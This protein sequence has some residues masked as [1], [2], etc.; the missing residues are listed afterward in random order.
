MEAYEMITY[1]LMD[2]L[3]IFNRL[4]LHAGPISS[5]LQ[6]IYLFI[7]VEIL[8]FSGIVVQMLKRKAWS[9]FPVGNADQETFLLDLI[10]KDTRLFRFRQRLGELVRHENLQ[11]SSEIY[12][13][14]TRLG[15]DMGVVQAR[16]ESVHNAVSLIHS[17]VGDV[18][19][20][21]NRIESFSSGVRKLRSFFA[22]IPEMA[23][24][25][26]A[27]HD[28]FPQIP[29][30][31]IGKL[32]NWL[33][34]HD[35]V[36]NDYST[37]RVSRFAGTCEWFLENPLYKAWHSKPSS[38]LFW[39]HG[40]PG[41]GKSVLSSYLVETEIANCIYFFF[42]FDDANK[43][44][45]QALLRSA[46]FQL[47][48]QYESIHD[49]LCKLC[50]QGLDLDRLQLGSLWQKIFAET[51]LKV[52]VTFYW[53]IDGLDECATDRG[54]LVRLLGEALKTQ[55]TIKIILVSRFSND[56][57]K[58]IR[59]LGAPVY[60]ITPADNTRDIARYVNTRMEGLLSVEHRDTQDELVSEI[61]GRAH[62]GF[63]WTRL[64]LDRLEAEHSIEGMRTALHEMPDKLVTVYERIVE[65][66]VSILNPSQ[67]SLA[68]A[69]FMYVIVA[70]RPLSLN[71]IAYVLQSQFGSLRSIKATIRDI[72]GSMI[73][74]GL[75]DTIH[76]IHM[77][78][79]QYLV[80]CG[81]E[82]Q[83]NIPIADVS[84]ATRCLEYLLTDLPDPFQTHSG[85]LQGQRQA[86]QNRHSFLDYAAIHWATHLSRASAD[87]QLLSLISQFIANPN[88]LKWLQYLA[89]AGKF[90]V[91][92]VVADNLEYYLD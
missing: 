20:T 25:M 36:V 23:L 24:S 69:I 48:E 70:V 46:A 50:D 29:E 11:L 71:E 44:Q 41:S 19:S 9:M 83:I 26:C 22:K 32:R 81:G 76:T 68:K 59:L 18:S 3:L 72:C 31:G 90:D 77:T 88:I 43:R 65:S 8:N 67:R 80:A 58:E 74:F 33:S 28:R 37:F 85:D 38:S 54:L 47:A 39:I 13:N 15:K 2:I 78:V 61:S 4:Q 35:D 40:L 12:Q 6:K 27:L 73:R 16:V 91:L 1:Q 42:R 92:R 79:R 14:V 82:F 84:V 7:L 64:V 30:S 62:G 52:P 51:I 60:E 63:L 34:V 21:L 53:F 56:I 86:V 10:R 49:A 55:S 17:E 57:A 5:G 75:Q 87:K 45:P 66:N 89:L